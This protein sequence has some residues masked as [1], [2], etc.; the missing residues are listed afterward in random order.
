MPRMVL[1]AQAGALSGRWQ[2][3]PC[4][5][6]TNS[7]VSTS[8]TAATL[9]RCPCRQEVTFK[10]AK[11]FLIGLWVTRAQVVAW[12]EGAP[13]CTP[14]GAQGRHLRRQNMW[15]TLQ[16]REVRLRAGGWVPTDEDREARAW[17]V[18]AGRARPPRWD[19]ER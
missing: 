5:V 1:A 14:L 18:P 4:H 15:Q 7:H 2:E 16:S 10:A 6:W 3:E 17:S 19:T 9:C 11:D 12:E 13:V 8:I